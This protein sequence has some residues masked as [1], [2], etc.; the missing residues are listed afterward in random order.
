MSEKEIETEALARD[1]DPET[2]HEAAESFDPTY[3]ESLVLATIASFGEAGGT[4]EQIC[5]RLPSVAY[6]TITPRFRPLLRKGLV[7]EHGTR[8]ASTGRRQRVLR[9]VKP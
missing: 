7:E 2:S 3:M 4:S 1:S 6:N 9:L 8:I 5:L